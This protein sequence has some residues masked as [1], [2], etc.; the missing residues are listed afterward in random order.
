MSKKFALPLALLPFLLAGCEDWGEKQP[1]RDFNELIPRF[2]N[3]AN[4]GSPEDAAANLF[5][6]TNPDERRDAIAYL[7]TKKYG[8]EPPYM[9]AYETLVTDPHPLV[10]GQAMLALGTSGQER[11]VPL[12]VKGLNDREATVRRDAAIALSN[13][14]GNEAIGPLTEHIRGDV[15]EQVRINCARALRHANTPDAIRA[16]IDAMDDRDAAVVYAARNSLRQNTQQ[17]FGYDAR[18]WLSWYRET[19]QASPTTAPGTP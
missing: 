3:A 8:H 4:K 16:L 2:M 6:T 12:L 17:D 11:I 7:Q 9:R 19:Y 14:F 5:N 10:R 1:T 13:T 18:A 15:D